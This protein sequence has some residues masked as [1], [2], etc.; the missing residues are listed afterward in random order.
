MF[1]LCLLSSVSDVVISVTYPS[2]MTLLRSRVSMSDAVPFSSKAIQ[3]YGAMRCDSPSMLVKSKGPTSP[4]SAMFVSI[5]YHP[6]V[7]GFFA[8]CF[9]TLSGWITMIAPKF[10]S[11]RISLTNGQYLHC[12]VVLVFDWMWCLM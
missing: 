4:S 12:L 8:M 5:W 7:S 1:L 2:G 10:P 6:R 9:S 3:W 11:G